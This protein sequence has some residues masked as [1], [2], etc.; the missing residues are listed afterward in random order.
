M[1]I[2]IPLQEPILGAIGVLNM[3]LSALECAVMKEIAG[4]PPEEAQA[5]LTIRSQRQLGSELLLR[6]MGTG[7]SFVE[8]VGLTFDFKAGLAKDSPCRAPII[9]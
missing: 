9:T 3:V 8:I 1:E 5:N 2:Q 6:L 4:M 7:A